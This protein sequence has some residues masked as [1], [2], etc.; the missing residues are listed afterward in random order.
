MKHINTL[1]FPVIIT[2]LLHKYLVVTFE[3][4]PISE[5]SLHCDLSYTPVQFCDYTL[6]V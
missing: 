5:L 3:T 6:Q 2:S 4:T 1:T